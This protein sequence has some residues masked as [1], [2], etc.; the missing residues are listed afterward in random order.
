[1]SSKTPITPIS[2]TNKDF[3]TIYPELL[4]VVKKLTYKWD[5][6]IS[7]ESDPGVILLKL[8]AIIGD[9]NN[10]NIDKNVLENFPETLTQQVS[11][12][13]IYKQLGYH[14]PWY[15]SSSCTVSFKWTGEELSELDTVIIPKYTMVT[16]TDE[17][18]VYTLTQDVTLSKNNTISSGIVLQGV[19][20]DLKVNGSPNIGL[21]NLDYNNRIY[22]DESSVAENGIFITNIGA[23]T[24]WTK[25]DNL[26]TQQRGQLLYEFGVD[27]RDN[28]CY[29]EFPDDIESIIGN[30]LNIKY[31]VSE[32]KEGNISPNTINSFYE[33]VTSTGT[34][35]TVLNK[36]N[37]LIKN[38]TAAIDGNNPESISDAYKSYQKTVGTF[39][40]LVTL[41]DYI[42]G[43]YN[44]ELVSNDV[45]SDRTNDLQSSFSVII[46]AGDSYTTTYIT[47]TND[48]SDL[49]AFDL[50]LYLLQTAGVVNNLTSYNKSFELVRSKTTEEDRVISALSTNKCIQHDFSPLKSNLPCVFQI[51]YPV[52][53]KI[54]PQYALTE[55]QQKDI[56]NKIL[57][58]LSEY[59]NARKVSFGIEPSYDEIY[60][61][62]LSADSRIKLVVMDDFNYSVYVSYIED[63]TNVIKTIPISWFAEYGTGP[64]TPY[65]IYVDNSF[66]VAQSTWNRLV[67]TLSEDIDKYYFVCKKLIVSDNTMIHTVYKYNKDTANFVEYSD[68]IDEFRKFVIAKNIFAG[69]TSLFNYV[70]TFDIS[71]GDSFIDLFSNVNTISTSLLIEPFKNVTTD[72][73]SYTLRANESLKFVA[74]S[75]ITDLTY[76]TY[77]KYDFISK[78]GTGGTTKINAD[79]SK[80]NISQ[81]TYNKELKDLF[82]LNDE[83]TYTYIAKINNNQLDSRLNLNVVQPIYVKS[84]YYKKNSEEFILVEDDLIPEDWGTAN[85]YSAPNDSNILTFT[86]LS[87]TYLKGWQ[88]NEFSVYVEIPTV[89][90][91]ANTDYQLKENEYITFFYKE[92]DEEN[93]PYIGVCYKGTNS[94]DSPIIRP[95][96]DLKGKTSSDVIDPTT[97]QNKT[98]YYYSDNVNS[99]YQKISAL[100]GTYDLSGT[101]SIDIRRINSSKYGLGECYYYF[102]S[103]NTTEDNKYTMTF[104]KST[105][106][107]NTYLYQLDS[108]E[109]FFVTDMNKSSYE[110]VGNNTL[111]KLYSP[112]ATSDKITLETNKIN[113]ID[114]STGGIDAFKDSCILN[115]NFSITL[116]EQQ[117]YNFVEGNKLTFVKLS[118][119]NISFETDKYTLIDPSKINLTYQTDAT[120]VSQTLPNLNLNENAMWKGTAILNINCD[121]N[122]SQLFSNTDV[123]TQSITIGPNKDNT[124]P[125]VNTPVYILSNATILKTGGTNVDVSYL[126]ATGERHNVDIIIYSNNDIPQSSNWSRDGSSIVYTRNKLLKGNTRTSLNVSIPTKYS[127]IVKVTINNEKVSIIPNTDNTVIKLGGNAT[128]LVNRHDGETNVFYYRVSPDT[129]NQQISFIIK[130]DSGSVIPVQIVVSELMPINYQ[131]MFQKYSISVSDLTDYMKNLCPEGYNNFKFD[132]KVPSN[133]LIAD[134]LEGYTFFNNLHAC[135]SYAIPYAQLSTSNINVLNTRG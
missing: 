122:R 90:I 58:S 6:S 103:K 49:T 32:G 23:N 3:Q 24:L 92:K 63:Q 7:N 65:I 21:V 38:I 91:D 70:D 118:N 57:I 37:C 123:S 31:L 60:D 33:D 129:D 109:Y 8:N 40:T 15:R 88:T 95:S 66:D 19:I 113:Y 89:Q 71:F 87:Y 46:D 2:Y 75:L 110:I 76:S 100:T 9:K 18:I 127:Y 130:N 98:Y 117:L 99:T 17:D 81:G 132:Y 16:T 101:K 48:V 78:N 43:V 61:T 128:E 74:P 41:R 22:F 116:Q 47:K 62:I 134:P 73:S 26:Q 54:I 82:I 52:S 50:K 13:N 4:D 77:V 93:S 45:V 131:N 28:L 94:I 11:A 59:L 20:N 80:F 135:N 105:T 10:Y 36:D 14:M 69:K 114:I 5:P 125:K 115:T 55:L 86:T 35:T 126:D 119:E 107:E 84:K 112:N 12:R 97:V 25:V 121:S 133:I 106:E 72:I 30:G 67:N 85:Y 44:T 79:Y 68:K 27:S 51:R 29:V 104:T 102:I 96:F 124:Y 83:G 34:N 64:E 120:G 108:D 111:V 53:I 56:I 1:M 42:N 39:N